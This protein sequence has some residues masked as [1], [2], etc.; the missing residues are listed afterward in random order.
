MQSDV[1]SWGI[2]TR[3]PSRE[4]F[5]RKGRPR[6]LWSPFRKAA[7][8]FSRSLWAPS[9]PTW[10]ISWKERSEKDCENK[11]CCVFLLTVLCCADNLA[12]ATWLKSPLK[13]IDKVLWQ[14]SFQDTWLLC[15]IGC[16]WWF[17]SVIRWYVVPSFTMDYRCVKPRRSM[18]ERWTLCWVRIS[19]FDQ[20]HFTTYA[21]R[22]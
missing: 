9:L 10:R 16:G 15:L 5:T 12:L 14:S 3:F 8:C 2:R 7:L 11:S 6:N 19:D 17:C 18:S 21:A 13:N 22:T 4:D 1:S 20:A